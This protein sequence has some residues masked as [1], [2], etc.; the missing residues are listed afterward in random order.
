MY[1]SPVRACGEFKTACSKASIKTSFDNFAVIKSVIVS[2]GGELLSDRE[3][4]RCGLRASGKEID[5]TGVM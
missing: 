4:Y 3:H 2:G 1:A 5:V